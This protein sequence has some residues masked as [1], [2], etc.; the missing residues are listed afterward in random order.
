MRLAEISSKPLSI[1]RNIEY[2]PRCPRRI[3]STSSKNLVLPILVLPLLLYFWIEAR[4]LRV[5]LEK[6]FI[7]KTNR[8]RIRKARG[9]LRRLALLWCQKK[10]YYCYYYQYLYCYYY[11]ISGSVGRLLRVLLKKVFIHKTHRERIRKGRGALR[12]L[13][14]LW[15]PKSENWWCYSPP[16]V[17]CQIWL[18]LA[19]KNLF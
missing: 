1:S 18:F 17:G 4:L 7:H 11:N 15:C 3:F 8:E 2:W 19:P 14:L 6:V 16:K 10:C 13:A 12:R 9:A 5:F